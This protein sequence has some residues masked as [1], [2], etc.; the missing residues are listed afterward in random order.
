MEFL[1][2][3]NG[4]TR[5]VLFLAGASV[6]GSGGNSAGCA[7]VPPFRLRCRQLRAKCPGRPQLKQPVPRTPPL[8]SFS[9][10]VGVLSFLFGASRRPSSCR[11][12]RPSRSCCHRGCSAKNFC[13][14]D[15]SSFEL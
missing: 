13:I 15:W 8:R 6:D 7:S 9:L 10:V 12:I 2:S 1:V 5:V 3:P 11:L 14:C 4:L